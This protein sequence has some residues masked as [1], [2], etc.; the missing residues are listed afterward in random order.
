MLPAIVVSPVPVVNV[1]DPAIA[2]LPFR[3]FVPEDVPNVPVPL[4]R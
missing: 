3:V 4:N 2:T 1:L